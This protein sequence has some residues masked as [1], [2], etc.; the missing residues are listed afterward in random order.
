MPL[1]GLGFRVFKVLRLGLRSQSGL[2]TNVSSIMQ[3]NMDT[4]MVNEMATGGLLGY[5]S[6]LIGLTGYVYK[7]ATAL[8]AM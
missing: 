3:K 7:G 5:F 1:G 6:G 8:R 4:E 2:C